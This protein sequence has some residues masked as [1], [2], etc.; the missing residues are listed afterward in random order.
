M[1]Q[2]H[3]LP[4]CSVFSAYQ[5]KVTGDKSANYC[6]PCAL[7]KQSKMEGCY[8]CWELEECAL[9]KNQD[10]WR[11]NEKLLYLPMV[12]YI[13]FPCESL[14]HRQRGYAPQKVLLT[15][16]MVQKIIWKADCHSA[17][18]KI[19]CFLME[20]EVSLPCSHKPATEPYPEAAESSSPNRSLSP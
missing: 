15:Y 7:P 11:P 3:Y 1:F 2:Y 17:C 19:S 10:K 16:S 12:N 6:L 4:M 8:M 18:Q 20:S 5:N 13:Y 14:W 9:I